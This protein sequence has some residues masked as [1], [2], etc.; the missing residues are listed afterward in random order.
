[1]FH[2][3]VIELQAAVHRCEAEV[4]FMEK[5]PLPFPVVANDEELYEHAKKVGEALLGDLNVQLSPISMGSEDFGFFTQKIPGTIFVLGIK[6]ESLKSDKALHSPFFFV[7][8]E[9]FPIGAALNAAVAMS[10]LDKHV[11]DSRG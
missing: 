4:D 8:E 1:M 11:V 3:Q 5:T 2:L 10:Y 9:A 7:D 6:N